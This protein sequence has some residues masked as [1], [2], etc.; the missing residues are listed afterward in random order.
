MN[1]GQLIARWSFKR[2]GA[3][4][5][6]L[7]V[8]RNRIYILPTRRGLLLAALLI[9]M[10]I[11]GLNYSNNLALGLAFLMCAVALAAMHHCHRNLL[12]LQIDAALASDSLAGRSAAHDFSIKNHSRLSHFDIDIRL[13]QFATAII[14]V[15][16]DRVQRCS[17][18]IPTASRGVL[19]FDRI[20]LQTRY[21]FGWFRAWT[22]A[23][24]GL[25]VYAAPTPVGRARA[26]AAQALQGFA[27]LP[28][29]R[30]DEDFMGL[31]DY[32]SGD[33]RKHIA[34]KSLARGADLAVRSYSGTGQW[35][36]WFDWRD[37]PQLGTEQRL[38]QLC[39]WIIDAD[40]AQRRYGLRLPG[41][42]IELGSGAAQRR[43]CLR[44]LAEYPEASTA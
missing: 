23:H 11:G 43:D 5:L 12:G 18:S 31:R 4:S 44:A 20:Q 30:G 26:V 14:T 17:V 27:A 39:Q 35:P 38:S 41:G 9:A 1:L 22:Y 29:G 16:A 21:P 33:L 37:L 19:R 36:E 15:A 25:T 10:L 24:V 7:T 42:T 34:W 28:A 8:V 2:H 40:A 3:D 32:A 13:S 6:P